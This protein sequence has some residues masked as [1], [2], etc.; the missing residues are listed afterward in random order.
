[1]PDDANLSEL[2]S[3][4]TESLSFGSVYKHITRTR[5]FTI[6]NTS[7]NDITG[8][9]QRVLDSET[10]RMTLRNLCTSIPADTSCTVTVAFQPYGDMDASDRVL[11]SQTDNGE[12]IYLSLSGRG[13]EDDN[14]WP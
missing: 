2:I 7:G 1:M 13:E 8:L 10:S 6:S 11:I 5:T 4:N 9:H 12:G 3:L 14:S